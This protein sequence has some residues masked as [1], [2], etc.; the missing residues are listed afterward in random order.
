MKIPHLADRGY[1]RV[2]EPTAVFMQKAELQNTL[3]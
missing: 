3:L 1:T 2:Q